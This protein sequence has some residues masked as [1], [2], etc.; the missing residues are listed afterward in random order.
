MWMTMC[1]LAEYLKVSKETI[2]KLAQ[3]GQLPGS[4]LG[5]QWRFDK[6]A[7]DEWLR[8]KSNIHEDSHTST[9]DEAKEWTS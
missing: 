9:I 6:D 5:N 7:V 1:E 4:K 8:S 3:R 2:Y